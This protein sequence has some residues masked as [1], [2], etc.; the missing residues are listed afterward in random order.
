MTPRDNY[1]AS[2]A[3]R[4]QRL[5]AVRE[6]A[7]QEGDTEALRGAQEVLRRAERDMEAVLAAVTSVEATS[8]RMTEAAE[9]ALAALLDRND[10]AGPDGPH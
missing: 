2:T 6:R 8:L 7:E 4:I 3:A 5:L 10:T 1:L 9:A